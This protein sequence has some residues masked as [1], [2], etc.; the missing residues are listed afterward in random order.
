V[1]ADAEERGLDVTL[2]QGTLADVVAVADAARYAGRVGVAHRAL[3]AQRERFAAST[4]ARTAAFLLGRLADTSEAQPAAAI[5]WYDRYLAESPGGE[6]ASEALGRKLVAVQ[7]V[8]GAVSARPIA[9]QYLR[10]FPQGPYAT[11]AR[12]L[13]LSP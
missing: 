2:A 11:K 4:A 5:G 8:S 13:T 9:E 3:L 10:R 7:R 12:E 1:L 6:F